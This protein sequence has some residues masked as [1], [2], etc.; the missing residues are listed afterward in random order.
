MECGFSLSMYIT[1]LFVFD[2]LNSLQEN[3]KQSFHFAKLLATIQ[4]CWLGPVQRIKEGRLAGMYE[5]KVDGTRTV[6]A[7]KNLG[8]V[9]FSGGR[10]GK[11]RENCMIQRRC[12]RSS[13]NAHALLK[14]K[15]TV[16][17]NVHQ[18]SLEVFFV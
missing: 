8:S 12:C 18:S 11:E 7:Y 3:L 17:Y 10:I 1:E 15:L 13:F 9:E 2:G 5:T 4:K 16:E 6:G 14:I